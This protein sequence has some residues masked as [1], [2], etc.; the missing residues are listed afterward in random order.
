MC[1]ILQI[2]TS[3]QGCRIYVCIDIFCI[4]FP[5]WNL[6][7]QIG[8]GRYRAEGAPLHSGFSILQSLDLHSEFC[9]QSTCVPSSSCVVDTPRQIDNKFPLCRAWS[10]STSPTL[11]TLLPFWPGFWLFLLLLSCLSAAKKRSLRRSPPSKTTHTRIAAWLSHLSQFR[12]AKGS[13]RKILFRRV[14]IYLLWF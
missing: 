1:S 14:T 9:I 12:S 2:K 10:F 7:M 6:R 3:V 13:L 5:L 8:T 11:S 4:R